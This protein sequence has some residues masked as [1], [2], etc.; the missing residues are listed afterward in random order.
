[1]HACAASQACA[2]T[3]ADEAAFIDEARLA[4]VVTKERVITR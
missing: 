4:F 3:R 1:M 2:T